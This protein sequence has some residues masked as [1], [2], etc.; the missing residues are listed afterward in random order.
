MLLLPDENQMIGFIIWLNKKQIQTEFENKRWTPSW[1]YPDKQKVKVVR[2]H[3]GPH[4]HR[5]PQVVQHDCH[6][7]A[8]CFVGSIVFFSSYENKQ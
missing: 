8:D 3:H 1:Q 2:F 6:N 7:F 5:K 4:E